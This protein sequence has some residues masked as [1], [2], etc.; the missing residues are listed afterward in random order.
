MHC[1]LP[2]HIVRHLLDLHQQYVVHDSRMFQQLQVDRDK[3]PNSHGLQVVEQNW[4]QC[5]HSHKEE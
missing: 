1:P 4:K 2:V 5:L 3:G